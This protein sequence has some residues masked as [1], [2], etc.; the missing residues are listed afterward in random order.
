MSRA[1]TSFR[2]TYGF[3][4][5][6]YSV[7]VTW[8]G[9][10]Y[11]NSEAAFQS[12]KS[13]DPEE[14]DAF[15]ALNG[16]AAKRQGRRSTLRRDWEE[17]KVGIM[18]EVVRAKFTQHPDLA[19]RLVETGD[20]ELLEGNGWH[21]AFWGVDAKTL[22]GENHL[23]RILMK[24]RTE[25]SQGDFLE[26]AEKSRAQQAEAERQRRDA[27]EQELRQIESQLA[28]LPACDFVG[29]EMGTKAF[30]RVKVLRQEGHYL[31]AQA[32][33]TE[34][35]FALPGCIL[36]GYLIPDDP[37]VAENLKTAEELQKKADSLQKELEALCP[38]EA[39][40]AE[41]TR[42]LFEGTEEY[43]LAHCI[44]ADFSMSRGIVTQFNKRFDLGKKLREAYPDYLTEWRDSGKTADCLLVGRVLNLVT[45][46]RYSFRPTYDAMQEAL[47]KMKTVCLQNHID[48]VAMPKIGCGL[49]RL[50]WDRV[51]A[52]IRDT[53]RDTGVRILVCV[54]E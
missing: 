54:K 5:N 37:A 29:M 17:V 26:E 43:Y 21:D 4:S 33:G 27:L 9:R 52:M 48:R 1:I 10:T 12:A 8:D 16:P 23:G 13:L 15:C 53:F 35:R 51:S 36:Q 42:D 24:I 2:G 19:R 44:S 11:Q 34:K 49:D 6:M 41:I 50:S 22:E 28:A 3:L 32:Q 20:A 40:Y 39:P 46:E 38:E 31:I 45:K 25:L 14:R 18:E 30:G 7:S 47:E